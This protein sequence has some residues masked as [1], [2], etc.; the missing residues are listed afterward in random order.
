MTPVTMATPTIAAA[1]MPTIAG[2]LML[3]E[4][5]LTEEDALAVLL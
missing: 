4:V 5:E 2:V 3:L 1:A